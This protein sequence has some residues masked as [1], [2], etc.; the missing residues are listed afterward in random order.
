MFCSF[1]FLH[2][3]PLEKIFLEFTWPCT[4]LTYRERQA[5]LGTG[6]VTTGAMEKVNNLSHVSS[7]ALY[8]TSL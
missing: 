1:R 2:S 4:H 8:L 5:L 6:K 7:S 3:S